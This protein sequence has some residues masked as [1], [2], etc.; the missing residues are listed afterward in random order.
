LGLMP[1]PEG[2]LRLTVRGVESSYRVIIGSETFTF[3]AEGDIAIGEEV[4][5]DVFG[6]AIDAD[7][8][9]EFIDLF[10]ASS[11]DGFVDGDWI[12]GELRS[13]VEDVAYG[14]GYWGGTN[15]WFQDGAG[16]VHALWHGGP[17]HEMANGEH[18]WI[19]TNLTDAAGLSGLVDFAPGSVS[20][21]ATGWNAFNIQG[22][23]DGVLVALWWS[24]ENSAGTYLDAQGNELQGRAGGLRGN[25]WQLSEISPF[26]RD[27]ETGELLEFGPLRPYTESQGNGIF[28]FDPRETRVEFGDGMSIVVVEVTGDVHLMSFTVSTG[29]W[30]RTSLVDAPSLRRFVIDDRALEFIEH[31]QDASLL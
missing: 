5:F 13:R 16:D 23:V 17:V 9:D 10:Q 4:E 6:D 24:P 2:P 1:A 15:H 22:I 31:Y 21:I 8:G 19:L 20:G 12:V 7:P 14:Q 30:Q 18:R 29:A 27:L 25:G 11:S 26:V 28:T 3:E